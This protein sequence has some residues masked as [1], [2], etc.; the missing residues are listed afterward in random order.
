MTD[1]EK[2]RAKWNNATHHANR[3]GWAPLTGGL[4]PTAPVAV[5][6]V[7]ND[8]GYNGF[9][10]NKPTWVLEDFYGYHPTC[11][12]HMGEVALGVTSQYESSDSAFSVVFHRYKG[13]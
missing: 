6:C 9:C 4:A 12:T 1:E 3:L 13:V 7:A 11:Q 2:V 5:D 8:P 10:H